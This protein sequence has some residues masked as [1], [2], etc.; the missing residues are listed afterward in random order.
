MFA[1]VI[2]LSLTLATPAVTQEQDPRVS[3]VVTEV[4]HELMTLPYYGVFDNLAFTDEERR[5]GPVAR[6]GVARRR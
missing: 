6:P 2:A 3:R 1:A 4:Q 5:Y